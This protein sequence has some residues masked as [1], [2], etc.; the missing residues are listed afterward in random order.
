MKRRE[1]LEYVTVLYKMQA[2]DSQTQ[3][4]NCFVFSNLSW[5]ALPIFWNISHGD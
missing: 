5:Q 4:L 1:G 3:S 2:L